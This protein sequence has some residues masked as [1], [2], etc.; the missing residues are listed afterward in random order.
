MIVNKLN[1]ESNEIK[2]FRLHISY[3]ILEGI[4]VGILVLNQFVFI[5]SL[6]GSSYLLG[7]LFQFSVIA[8]IFLI[9]F[10]EFISRTNNKKKMLRTMSFITRLPLI[11][12]LFFPTNIA[13]IIGN[14]T[15]N[16][17][18]LLVFLIFYLSDPIIFPT[19]NLL[20]KN[21]YRHKNFGKLYGYSMT[22]KNI[23][24]LV[25]TFIY[26]FLLDLDN[27]VFVY[28]FPIMGIL[29]II[30]IFLLSNIRFEETGKDTVK[31]GFLSSIFKSFMNMKDIIKTDKSFRDFEIGFMLYGFSFMITVTI[32][33][34]FFDK[35]LNLNYSSVAFY[36]NA[37]LIVAIILT[38]FFGRLI[39]KI[40]PRKFAIFTFIAMLLSI[41]GLILTDLFPYNFEFFGIKFYWML[42]TYVSFYGIFTA[43]MVLLW[44]IGSAY[45]CKDNEADMYQSV[46]LSATGV[47]GLFAPIVGV[48]I[49]EMIGFLGTFF[50]AIGVLF[51]AIL[52]MARSY[53]KKEKVN[54]ID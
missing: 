38:P 16:Y 7:I 34:L 48:I 26:G 44:H 43:T 25:T 19:T 14:Q 35:V 5:K 15:Y 36:K 10:N 20:L 53:K 4:I 1:L 42:M 27:Y 41:F 37:Y 13:G 45:F 17:I 24:A 54:S 52:V 23:I 50:I 3:S 40:D 8:F 22:I 9:F 46:H 39:G 51:I 49:Y 32:I 11:V 28:V 29:G 31:I 30:S 12:F 33:T 21:N 47:R 6:N 18:F 2:T